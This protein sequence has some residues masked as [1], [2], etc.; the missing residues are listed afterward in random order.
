V[1]YVHWQ[2]DHPGKAETT[3]TLKTGVLSLPRTKL[4]EADENYLRFE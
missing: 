2:A 3:Q 4:V 1:E